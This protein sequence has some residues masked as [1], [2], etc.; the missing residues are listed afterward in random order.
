MIVC[1]V[2][3]RVRPISHLISLSLLKFGNEL[4][5]EIISLFNQLLVCQVKFVLIE[6]VLRLVPALRELA[7]AGFHGVHLGA[8][9]CNDFSQV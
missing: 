6:Q 8:L 9:A 7:D 2:L 4:L 1:R 5:D 3:R